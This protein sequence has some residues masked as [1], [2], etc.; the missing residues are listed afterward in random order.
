[1]SIIRADSVSPA[2][3][4]TTRNLPRGVAAAWANLNGTGT[5]ALRD[6][7]NISGV[8]DNG[9]G[10]HSFSFTS[11]MANANYA[12]GGS[13]SLN[14]AGASAPRILSPYDVATFLAGSCRVRTGDDTG[15]VGDCALLS[16]LY[17]GS[18]A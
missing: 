7:Q 15:A 17:F 8:V 18:L 14:A 2:A 13:A 1:M 10:D 12:M 16:P 5:I 4:G 6:S 11:A 9:T 3:G